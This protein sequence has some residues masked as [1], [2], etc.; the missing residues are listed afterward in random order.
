MQNKLK[1]LIQHLRQDGIKDSAVLKAIEKVDR[2]NF[3]PKEY[4]KEAYAD[5]PIDVG[6]GA[7]ISQP[8]TVAFMLQALELKKGDKVLEIGT[9]SGWN[10]A[11]ISVI[12]GKTGNVFTTE[13]IPELAKRAKEKLKDYKNIKVIL[14]DG[15]QG[16][17]EYSPFNKI[18]VTAACPEVPNTLVDQ[19]KQDGI[20]I[21]PVGLPTGQQMIKIIKAKKI[22]K[23]N[24]GEFVFVPLRGKYGFT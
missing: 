13:I 10:A 15:S 2:K 11:L 24:L 23:E 19:L 9:A 21:A 20:L 8:Y 22:I 16:L 18:I 5:Y 6:Y 3:I 17:K 12:V 7:T 4:E 14:A 1:E